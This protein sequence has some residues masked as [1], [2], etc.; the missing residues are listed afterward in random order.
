MH[1]GQCRS[2]GGARKSLGTRLAMRSA[3]IEIVPSARESVVAVVP[4]CVVACPTSVVKTAEHVTLGHVL[5]DCS[6]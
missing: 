4:A 1:A 3:C 5:C 6:V 2:H